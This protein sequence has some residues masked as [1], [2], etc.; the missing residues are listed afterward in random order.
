MIIFIVNCYF[1]KFAIIHK[2]PLRAAQ[3][4]YNIAGGIFKVKKAKAFVG[5][6]VPR[7]DRVSVLRVGRQKFQRNFWRRLLNKRGRKPPGRQKKPFC[8]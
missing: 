8:E 4:R 6:K 3:Q 2:K 1:D 7:G 5:E